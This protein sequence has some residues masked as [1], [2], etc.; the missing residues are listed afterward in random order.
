MSRAPVGFY[1]STTLVIIMGISVRRLRR[2]FLAAVLLILA[3]VLGAYFYARRGVENALKQ[4]PGKI[5][6]NIEQSAQGFTISNSERGR[7]LFKLVAS[8]AIQFKQGG[9]AELHDVTITLYGRDSSRFD[10][11]YGKDFEYDPASGDVTSRGDVSIDLEANPQGGENPDQTLPKELK[12]PIHL[13]TRDLVF[14]RASGDAWTRAPIEFRVSQ[15]SGSAVGAHYSARESQLSLES[16]VTVSLSGP[17]PATILAARANLQKNPR[18]VV[19]AHAELRSGSEQGRAD[20]LVLLLHNDNTLDRTLAS[21]HVQL[22]LSGDHPVAVSSE[23]LDARLK[24]AGI[25]E[26]LFSGN[27]AFNTP[28]DQPAEGTAG[29]VRLNFQDRH[30]LAR[31]YADEHVTLIEHQRPGEKNAED[32]KVVAPAIDFD[33][34][35]GNRLERA[36]TH[37]PPEILV[38][39]VARSGLET[40]AT[41]DAFTAQF[42]SSGSLQRVHGQGHARVVTSSLAATDTAQPERV[43]TSDTLDAFFHPA[44]GLTALVQQ[45]NFTYTAGT[46]KA[47]AQQ[48]RYTAADQ[49]VVLTGEPRIVGAG[50]T[51]TAR[52]VRLNRATG[53]AFAEGE[54]KTTYRD[55]KPQPGGALLATSDPI[56]VAADE[57]LTTSQAGRATYRGGARLWQNANLV[58]AATIE[59]RKDERMVTAL[60][61]SN[62]KVSTTLMEADRGGKPVPV[63]ITSARLSYR[64]AERCARYEGGVTANGGDMTMTAEKMDVWLEP[65]PS[66]VSRPASS[67]RP[68]ELDKIVASGSVRVRE[69][70]RQGE[71]EQLIYTAADDKFVLSGGVPSIFDAERGKITGVSLTLFRGDDRVVVEGDSSSPAVAKTRVVR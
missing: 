38:V 30:T 28:G 8:R 35:G 58:E 39:P 67:S 65:A 15:A 44:D 27:V 10:Q 3:V 43:T 6:L 57:M 7:T 42:D 37:G 32:L 62:G 54:V 33:L 51:T 31:A 1:R 2:W 48:A 24:P 17:T 21:G 29:R 56:H 5:G 66:G 69:P 64:D 45:G 23:R 70:K 4:V 60:G 9:R 52:L 20:Q 19:L 61:S 53:E 50:S 46:D 34:R 71:G 12:N 47:F 18:Q 41:A 49:M 14:N 22:R 63:H 11:I 13:R 25:E 36:E 59:F 55:L 16:H 26:A 40:R 68:A